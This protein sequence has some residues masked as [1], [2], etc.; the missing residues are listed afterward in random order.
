MQKL[1]VCSLQVGVLLLLSWMLVSLCTL[2]ILV[3][4]VS[5][6]IENYEVASVYA[7]QCI[8]STNRKGLYH[9]CISN[10]VLYE[11]EIFCLN[12]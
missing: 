11:S 2:T 9:L 7:G 4:A 12:Q 1:Y 6:P 10:T 8:N 3:I 5:D